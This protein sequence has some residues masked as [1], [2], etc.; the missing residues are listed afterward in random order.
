MIFLDNDT[1]ERISKHALQMYPEECCGILLG[2]KDSSGTGMVKDVFKANNVAE[3]KDRCCHFRICTE[4]L[5]Y[6][7]FLAAK[8]DYDILGFYHS[9]VD[10][11]A[12]ASFEDIH[13]AIP[14]LSY[15]IVSTGHNQVND[16]CSFVKLSM[17]DS[18]YIKETVNF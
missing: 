1:K 9:H 6:A 13:N 17:E 10:C 2:R 15:I 16:I 14:G 8:S 18:N 7:E 4:A 5:L 11:D 12:R 3:K